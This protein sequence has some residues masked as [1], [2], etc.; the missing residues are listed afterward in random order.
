MQEGLTTV[1][2]GTGFLGRAIVRE[3]VEAGRPVRI[4]ARHPQLPAWREPGDRIEAVVCD[5]RDEAQL[6]AALEGSAAAIN[7]VSLY[8]ERRRAGL[9]FTAI[10]QQAAGRLARM[11][12]ETGIS[13][14][15]HISG[16]GAD[17]RSP[18]A[19]VRARAA[20]EDAVIEALPKAILVRP[21]VLF[22]PDDALLTNLARLVRL[23]LVPLFGRGTTRLQP[24]HVNDVARAA[25]RLTAARPVERRLFELAGPEAYTYRELVERVAA[26]LE[27]HPRLVP[28]PFLAWR[29]AAALLTPLPSP[30]LTRDQVLLMQRDNLA[31]P[32][33]GSFADLGIMPHTL[34]DSLPR[35]LTDS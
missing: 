14:L 30:P 21:G 4:A 9:T 27:R 24:V 5:I 10:H 29:L 18:S 17:A 11:A 20:G 28:I 8:V 34:H 15:V 3:L 19:Y 22:G 35:C 13:R 7:A 2:G 33:T 25:A 12:R 31:D 32:D 23:P 16:I 1:F 6:A 26:Q